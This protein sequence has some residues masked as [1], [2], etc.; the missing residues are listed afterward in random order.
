MCMYVSHGL[1]ETRVSCSVVVYIIDLK[2]ELG[3]RPASPA[4]F[5]SLLATALELSGHVSDL[6][7]QVYWGFELNSPYLLGKCPPSIE[8]SPLLLFSLLLL[9]CWFY[10]CLFVSFCLFFRQGHL[11]ESW[12]YGHVLIYVYSNLYPPFVF[13]SLDQGEERHA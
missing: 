10:F 6:A 12:S 7:F 4:I 1:T 2:L 3:W 9:F 13:S 8:P 11:L 5:M